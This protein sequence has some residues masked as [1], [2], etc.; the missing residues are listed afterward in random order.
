M[1]KWKD[2]F[3]EIVD[4]YVEDAKEVGNLLREKYENDLNDPKIRNKFVIGASILL[5]IT[6]LAANI[7][8]SFAYY[9][10]ESEGYTLI[11]ATVGRMYIDDYDY[12]LLIFV[13]SNEDEGIYKLN[14]EIPTIGYTYNGYSC[15]NNSNLLYTDSEKITRTTLREKDVCSLYFKVSR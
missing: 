3:V 15:L 8:S 12:T 5:V 11:D 1:N 9:Y 14:K 4:D 2:K 6:I 10:D 7:F 13:E